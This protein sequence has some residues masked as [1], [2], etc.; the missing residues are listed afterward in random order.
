MSNSSYELLS[1]LFLAFAIKLSPLTRILVIPLHLGGVV[2]IDKNWFWWNVSKQN[3]NKKFRSWLKATTTVFH[4]EMVYF[5]CHS[6]IWSSIILHTRCN[7]WH[8][9]IHL[10]ALM[11]IKHFFLFILYERNVLF[12]K[13]YKY[14]YATL[15]TLIRILFFIQTFQRP[16]FYICKNV[17]SRYTQ[18]LCIRS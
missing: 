5:Y 1:L 3:L 12:S 18:W 17:C 7:I 11:L 2:R 16:F 10:L 9:I 4:S 13:T 6:K 8:F 15:I 14:W